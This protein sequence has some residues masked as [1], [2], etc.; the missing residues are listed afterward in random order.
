MMMWPVGASPCFHVLQMMEAFFRL[1]VFKPMNVV[2]PGCGSS[3]MKAFGLKPCKSRL[4]TAGLGQTYGWGSGLEGLDV[5]C[6][7]CG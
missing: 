6:L 3:P 2:G 7:G 1:V 4:T 5:V